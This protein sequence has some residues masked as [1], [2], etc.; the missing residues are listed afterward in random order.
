MLS[1]TAKINYLGPSKELTVVVPHEGSNNPISIKR[2]DGSSIEII[3]DELR[4][5]VALAKTMG[6]ELD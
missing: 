3:T 4:D 5:I 6:W 1:I 2:T